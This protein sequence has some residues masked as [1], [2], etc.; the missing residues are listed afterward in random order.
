MLRWL[1]L[2]IFS[3]KPLTHSDWQGMDM[4]PT[5][6]ET[7]FPIHEY[8]VKKQLLQNLES[9]HISQFTKLKLIQRH[10]FLR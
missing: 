1:L 7:D 2:Y 5:Q 8:L 6:N 10:S 3:K 4:R 9:P